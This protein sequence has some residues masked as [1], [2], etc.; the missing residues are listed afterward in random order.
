[1]KQLIRR[2][3]V[4]FSKKRKR[5]FIF[6]FSFIGFL[7]RKKQNKI[8]RKFGRDFWWTTGLILIDCRKALFWLLSQQQ[9]DGFGRRRRKSAECIGRGGGWIDAP[10]SVNSVCF[11]EPAPL[12]HIAH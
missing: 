1:M 11:D 12:P 4:L 8:Y 2:R 3:I 5:R 7:G 6:W 10:S 9:L